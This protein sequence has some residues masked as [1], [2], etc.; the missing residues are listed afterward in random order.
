MSEI[1]PVLHIKNICLFLK[2]TT[3]KNIWSE[4]KVLNESEWGNNYMQ[5]VCGKLISVINNVNQVQVFFQH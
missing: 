5:I 4:Q 1:P 3:K 2:V